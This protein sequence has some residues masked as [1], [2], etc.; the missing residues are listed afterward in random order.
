MVLYTVQGSVDNIQ[1]QFY[2]EL[3]DD[4]QQWFEDKVN[5]LLGS[6]WTNNGNFMISFDDSLFKTDELEFKPELFIV[7]RD[8]NG[9]K[10][11]TSQ[12]KSPSN[13]SD[14]QNLSFPNLLT[15]SDVGIN[16]DQYSSSNARRF[17]AF[18]RIGDGIDV[19]VNDIANTS[20]LLLQSLNA[21][22]LYTDE[23]L[24]SSIGYDGPQ[25]PKHSRKEDHD[26]KLDWEQ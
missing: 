1:E 21:W 9:K 19:N 20:T 2:V 10:I 4:D 5:D 13:S 15:H 16:Y 18:G 25:V 6:A 24:W 11:Y 23:M 22:L 17:S 12:K 14:H 26:H 7:V 3:F 8:K